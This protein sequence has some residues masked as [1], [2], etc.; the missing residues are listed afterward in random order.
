MDFFTSTKNK[1]IL[2]DVLNNHNV[3]KNIK[4]IHIDNVRQ[5][6]HQIINDVSVNFNRLSLIE[7]NKKVLDI[8]THNIN[9][10]VSSN[11]DNI[12]N[13]M[14]NNLNQ[15]EIETTNLHANNN[16]LTQFEKAKLDFE[17]YNSPKPPKEIDFSDDVYDEPLGD[18]MNILLEQQQKQREMDLN[19][20]FIPKTDNSGNFNILKDMSNNNVDNSNIISQLHE[21]NNIRENINTIIENNINIEKK[22]NEIY[23]ILIELKNKN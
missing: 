4:N 8:F 19:Q 21:I 22:I 13:K 11:E 12:L 10:I 5:L 1:E 9:I 17:Q 7:K 23:D 3:F 2:W 14:G 6:F 15:R 18:K 16:N 20:I